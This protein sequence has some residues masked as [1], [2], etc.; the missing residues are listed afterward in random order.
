M[1]TGNPPGRLDYFI[2]PLQRYTFIFNFQNICDLFLF[3][4]FKAPANIA[5]TIYGKVHQ[6]TN[7]HHI[8]PPGQLA[9]PT[10]I[11]GQPIDSPLHLHTFF[12]GLMKRAI[13]NAR[14]SVNPAT[15]PPIVNAIAHFLSY[16]FSNSFPSTT[17][18][19]PSETKTT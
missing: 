18:Y 5:P 19:K 4:S 12:F 15:P 9:M 7:A 10:V 11:T 17:L 3:F 1:V 2:N 6:F 16:S 8:P 13:L 14:L